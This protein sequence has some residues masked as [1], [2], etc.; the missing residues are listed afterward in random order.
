MLPLRH[1][2]LLPGLLAAGMALAQTDTT[3]AAEP[4][5][6]TLVIA[7]ELRP[8]TLPLRGPITD[9]V[10]VDSAATD[11]AVVLDW[12]AR[13]QPTRATIYSAILPGAGQIYN[14][15]YW[16]APIVWVGL[17]TCV[18]F[19]QDNNKQYQRY[20]TAYLTSLDGDPNTVDEFGGRYQPSQL[21]NVADTYQRWRDLSY[22]AF[23]LV[24]ILNIVDATVD[25]YFVRFDVSPGLSL[26]LRPS[27]PLA[28][29]GAAGFS[30]ALRL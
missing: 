25:G 4:R 7:P 2:L 23:G 26:D 12:R 5:A 15:K 27:L 18:F 30:L 13:H 1:S 29:Q 3:T 20:K 11:T 10:P 14:R 17:G 19:I 21:R 28:A 6:D 9:I 16:K 22:V 8:D 24:Y